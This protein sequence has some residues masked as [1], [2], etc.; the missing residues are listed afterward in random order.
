MVM[1]LRHLGA[2]MGL[3]SGNAYACPHF[4]VVLSCAGKRFCSSRIRHPKSH[5]MFEKFINVSE[6][7]LN[8]YRL[9][10]QN[11]LSSR[12]LSENVKIKI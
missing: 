1:R 4:F 2:A 7:I 11:L 8:G 9:S 12:L 6:L 3:R 5:L 10:V